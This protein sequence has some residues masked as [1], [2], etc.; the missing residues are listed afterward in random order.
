M[1]VILGFTAMVALIFAAEIDVYDDPYR[2][3]FDVMI[4]VA[5]VFPLFLAP[6]TYLC[7]AGDRISGTMKYA[8]GLPN[9]RLE[10]FAGKVL[11]R[12]G[13][14]AVA[15]GLSVL[16]GFAIAA[17]TFTNAP[18]PAR[19]LVLGGTSLL[20]AI[21]FGSLFVAISASTA[22]RSRAMFGAIGAYFVLVIF[23]FGFTPLLN[24]ENLLNAVESLGGVTISE[25]TRR[26][27][28]TLSPVTAYLQAS[29]PA[30][31]GVIDQYP[32]FQQFSREDE[33][34]AKPWFNVLVLGAWTTLSLAVGYLRFRSSEL[35]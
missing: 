27:I 9:T 10:Y 25:E 6:L 7:I 22:S 20:L 3:L 14:A 34:Y 4:F 33:L 17:A 23:W 19:F 1:G 8:M 5:F 24:L 30:F 2:T 35:G 11:S 18:D 16:V 21:A 12:V 29:K 26:Y 31:D 15:V 32:A 13:V 28:G